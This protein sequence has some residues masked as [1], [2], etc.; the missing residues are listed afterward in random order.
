RTVPGEPRVAKGPVTPLWR[1]QFAL[2][3]EEALPESLHELA[4]SVRYHRDLELFAVDTTAVEFDVRMDWL[5]GELCASDAT[6]RVVF[7]HHPYFSFVGD[8]EEEPEQTR[9]RARFDEVLS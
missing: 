5:A 6:W 2:P 9:R 8:G 4:Y 1:P 7:M 3:V